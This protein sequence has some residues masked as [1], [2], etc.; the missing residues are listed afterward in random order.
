MKYFSNTILSLWLLFS[1]NLISSPIFSQNSILIKNTNI[2]TVATDKVLKNTDVLIENGVI[3]KIGN[4]IPINTTYLILDGKGKFLMPSLADMHSHIPLKND[5]KLTTKHYLLLQLAAGVTTLRSMR[6]NYEHLSLKDSVQKE[7]ILSP[8]L[9]LSAPPI[10]RQM[11]A[12]INT[13]SLIQKYKADGFDFI[14]ILSVP[15]KDFYKKIQESA[16][17]VGL[18]VV[19]HLPAGDLDMALQYKQYSIE[20]LQGYTDYYEKGLSSEL[21]KLLDLTVQNNVYNC[22]TMDWT[23]VGSLH[24]SLQQLKDRVGMDFLPELLKSGWEKTLVDYIKTVK[25][26]EAKKDSLHLI[27]VQ[28]VIAK[29]RD[30]KCKII[31]SPDASGIFQVPGF[32]LVE[33]MKLFKKFGFSNY[34]ILKSATINAAEYFGESDKNGFVKENYNANLILLNA[35]PLENV[36]NISKIDGVILNGK[37]YSENSLKEQL[38][39]NLK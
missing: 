1:F 12:N 15:S 17:K 31:L 13:D 19:G 36:E 9:V 29:M 38:K 35:N 4:K 3:K 20:H 28:N 2:I 27:S 24:Y 14:K 30:K 34:E 33:E 25:P 18:K 22:P 26:D 23:F 37:W 7:F 16:K 10:T 39:Q 11:K 21:E 8:N 6:G 5:K 32:G